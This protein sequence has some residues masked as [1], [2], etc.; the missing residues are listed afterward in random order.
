[1]EKT[2]I[3]KPLFSVIPNGV[4]QYFTGNSA[5]TTDLAVASV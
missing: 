4:I 2:P 3:E 5:F 1:M